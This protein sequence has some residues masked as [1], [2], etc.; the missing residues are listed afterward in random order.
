MDHGLFNIAVFL[1]LKKAFDTVNHE[2]L[3]KKLGFYGFDSSAVNLLS[4]YLTNRSQMC[5]VDGHFSSPSE[6]N[7]GIPQG[8]ILGPLLFLIYVNYLPNC[9]EN[10]NIRMFADDTTQTASGKSIQQI[11]SK[12]NC[13]LINIKEWLLANK[14]S[15]NLTKTEYLVIGSPFNLN[16][17]TSEP[18]IM[19]DNVPIKRA[20][21]T[22]SLGIQIDQF[23]SSDN[24]FEEKCKKAS[25]GIGAIRRLKS[26]VS[27]ESLI[28]VYYALVQ[29]YFDYCCLVWDPIGATLS[30]RIQTLQNR[31]ARVILGYRNEHGQS[32]AALSELGWK[33][34]K[35]RR[36]IMKARLMYKIT[37]SQAPV[38]LTEI[39]ENSQQIYNLRNNEFK[40]YLQKPNTEYLKKSIGFC[41]A[42]LW[43]ELSGNLRIADCLNSFNTLIA[44]TSLL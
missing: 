40:L 3:T 10:S 16:N 38:A 28:S 7:Y 26:Y 22:K 4:S 32:E 44:D 5:C 30:N 27:R 15:L 25:S 34:L 29:P 23:L 20:T 43:N 1:D 39:F 9:V 6:I 8:S 18:N 37:H 41:G 13:D 24:H 35:E 42:K 31:A 2:I 11:E 19:I 36:L 21:K 33:T 17:L 14:L 12:I